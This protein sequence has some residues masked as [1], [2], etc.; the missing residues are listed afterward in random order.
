M[1]GIVNP[2]RF[3]TLGKYLLQRLSLLHLWTTAA[4]ATTATTLTLTGLTAGTGYN[5]QVRSN[6]SSATSANAGGQFNTYC[7]SK[8]NSVTYEWIDYVALGSLTR[9]SGA[10]AGYY[11]GTSLSTNLTRGTNNTI[12]LSAGFRSTIYKEFGEYGLIIIEMRYLQM[13]ASR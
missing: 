2:I 3:P 9:S 8:G 6:C 7:N 4:S 10:D 1:F 5:W 11:N 13:P 12:T